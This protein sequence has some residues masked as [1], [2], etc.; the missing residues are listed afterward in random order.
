MFPDWLQSSSYAWR[1]SWI[2]ILDLSI[3][4]RIDTILFQ[5]FYRH[6]AGFW[7]YFNS[8]SGFKLAVLFFKFISRNR[9][10]QFPFHSRQFIR[11]YPKKCFCGKFAAKNP[12]CRELTVQYF[13]YI[14]FSSRCNF[15]SNWKTWNF[16]R[17]FVFT[18]TAALTQ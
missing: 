12:L 2:R 16:L 8:I 6:L 14:E 11:I 18:A 15:S 1:Q 3:S 4:P 13:D 5:S 10:V 7:K 17:I 9:V